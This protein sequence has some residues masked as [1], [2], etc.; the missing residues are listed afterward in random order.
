MT[1]QQIGGHSNFGRGSNQRR[2]PQSSITPSVIH[3]TMLKGFTKMKS[4][5]EPTGGWERPPNASGVKT[6]IASTKPKMPRSQTLSIDSRFINP[7]NSTG[8]RARRHVKESIPRWSGSA[9]LCREIEVTQ[10]TA[11]DCDIRSVGER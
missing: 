6:R 11:D 9:A 2:M 5:E 7:V 3:W 10:K 4:N 1:A 8:M